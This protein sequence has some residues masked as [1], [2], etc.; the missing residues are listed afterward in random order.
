MK[1]SFCETEGLKGVNG[2][3]DLFICHECVDDLSVATE[4]DFEGTCSWCGSALVKNRGLL[5]RQELRAVAV[6]TSGDVILCSQCGKL[7]RDIVKTDA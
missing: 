7:C 3:R 2:P 4:M 6:N 1:C 5:N